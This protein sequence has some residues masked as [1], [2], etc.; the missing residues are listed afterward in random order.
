MTN[1]H[2]TL[3]NFTLTSPNGAN[4]GPNLTITSSQHCATVI[5]GTASNPFNDPLQYRWLEG[6]T[7]LLDWGSVGPGANGAASLDLCN[8]SLNLGQHTLLLEVREGQAISSDEM[9]LTIDNSAPN[10]APSGAGIYQIGEA[11]TVGG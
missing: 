9:I 2:H 5:Q 3:D 10:A 7:V 1:T 8:V 11:I 4:A 6:Q